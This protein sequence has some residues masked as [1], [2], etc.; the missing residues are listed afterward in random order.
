M[1]SLANHLKYQ[2]PEKVLDLLMKAYEEREANETGEERETGLITTVT[3]TLPTRG[4]A[5]QRER[6]ILEHR[7][8]LMLIDISRAIQMGK[9]PALSGLPP[10]PVSRGARKAAKRHALEMRNERALERARAG[11][12][13]LLP[14]QRLQRA[15]DEE[16]I[17]SLDAVMDGV[18]KGD[19][20]RRMK[21]EQTRA[22]IRRNKSLP[23]ERFQRAQD[24]EELREKF[25]TAMGDFQEGDR[26]TRVK[27]EQTRVTPRHS[28][29]LPYERLQQAPLPDFSTLAPSDSVTIKKE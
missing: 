2:P 7:K 19:G 17:D 10:A 3:A 8:G 6:E 29:R 15:G 25:E 13:A 26:V 28:A 4:H 14:Y 20:A 22:N 9:D 16:L 11:G 24:Q 5:K 23:S 1:R 12:A 21:R 18:R 27:E